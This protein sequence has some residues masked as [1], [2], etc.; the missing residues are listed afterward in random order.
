MGDLR[1]TLFLGI[2]LTSRRAAGGQQ[3]ACQAHVETGLSH[4]EQVLCAGAPH[5]S[6]AWGS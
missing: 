3:A 2:V 6:R 5:T 4:K 1:R